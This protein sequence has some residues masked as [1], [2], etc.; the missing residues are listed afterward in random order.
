VNLMCYGT[1]MTCVLFSFVTQWNL[2]ALV[3]MGS[4]ECQYVADAVKEVF[5]ACGVKI[6][7]E[8]YTDDSTDNS[9]A[10]FEW[11]MDIKTKARS[12]PNRMLFT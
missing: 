1:Y 2:T 12:R 5:S 6:A 4:N 7:A 11:L 8:L 3:Y 9:S 10:M